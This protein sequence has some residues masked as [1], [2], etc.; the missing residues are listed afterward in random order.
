AAISPAL[1][2]SRPVPHRSLGRCPRERGDPVRIAMVSGHP[3]ED[4][5]T[6]AVFDSPL[7]P[8]DPAL[9]ARLRDGTAD[10]DLAAPPVVL[11]DFCHK[12]QSE[13]P[14]SIAVATRG[15]IRPTLT[16]SALNCGMALATL[17]LE[18]PGERAVDDFYRRVRERYPV[19]P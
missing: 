11:P 9:L 15:A 5:G 16:D 10:A 6:A 13:M 17:D 3:Q 18:R 14:S 1:P 19:P 7:S 4:T 8:A 2:E 12:P